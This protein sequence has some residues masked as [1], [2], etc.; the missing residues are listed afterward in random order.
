MLPSTARAIA[1]CAA[2]AWIAACG[3]AG[4]SPYE[5]GR[6]AEAAGDARAARGL[7]ERSCRDG[8]RDGCAAA[9]RLWAAAAG[10]PGRETATRTLSARA[11]DLGDAQSC[12]L[13]GMS[14]ESESNFQR[15]MALA[16][17]D[18]ADP[19]L[20]FFDQALKMYVQGCLRASGA[21]AERAAEC[22]RSAAQ[23]IAGGRVE[24]DP[25]LRA[26]VEAR[27]RP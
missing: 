9:L 27:V 21:G 15:S 23:L 25:D 5:E 10:D 22:C 7:F 24:V 6:R 26:Q 16:Y 2:A 20:S 12:W 1:A 11:C 4:R 3:D 14:L 17:G 19:G 13:A 18:E 8:G